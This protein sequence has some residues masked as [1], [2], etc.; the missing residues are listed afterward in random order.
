MPRTTG[1]SRGTRPATYGRGRTVRLPGFDYAVDRPVHLT[2]CALE[3]GPFTEPAAAT[4][5]CKVLERSADLSGHRLYAYCLMP[6]HLHVLVS[7][8]ES[9]RPVGGFLR[10]FKSFSTREYQCTAG[11]ARLWQ[12]TAHDRVVR[13]S[14]DVAWLAEYIA[15]NPVRAGLVECWTEWPYSRVFV[16]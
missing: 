13:K 12:T 14:E 6:D 1:A 4:M 2:V 8:A 16:E 15:N 5:V 7:P 3:G 9:G 11:V 10:R